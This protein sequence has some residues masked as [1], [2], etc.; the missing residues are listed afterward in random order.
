MVYEHTTAC[1][2]RDG[3]AIRPFRSA[4]AQEALLHG[5]LASGPRVRCC[6]PPAFAS[7]IAVG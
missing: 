4:A 2:R 5:V 7:I 6:P 1:D 3:F